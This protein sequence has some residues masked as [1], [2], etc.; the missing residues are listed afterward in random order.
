MRRLGRHVFT[1]CWVTSLLILVVVL[2]AWAGGAYPYQATRATA[3]GRYWQVDTYG[4]GFN[5][6]RHGAALTVVRGWPSDRPW[7]V[8]ELTGVGVFPH[9]G[10][11]PGVY[12]Q[13][14]RSRT[15]PLLAWT[16]G[17][18]RN[19]GPVAFAGG[20]CQPIDAVETSPEST[21]RLS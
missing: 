17:P 21:G 2:A 13:S 10:M 7:Q 20:T 14:T 8:A 4:D 19:V 15:E 16:P 11:T 1:L 18:S 12:T 5:P 9:A 6:L 3:G